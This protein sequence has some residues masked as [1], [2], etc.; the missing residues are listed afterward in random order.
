MSTIPSRTPLTD[1][2]RAR[3]EKLP[4]M[5]HFRPLP[6]SMDP[7][8][9]VDDAGAPDLEPD[10]VALLPRKPST[11]PGWPS[12]LADAALHGF[13]GEF[14]RTVSPHSE[15]D[16][17]ALV[18]SL[19]VGFGNM[20]NAGPHSVVESKPHTLV[21]FA[22]LVGD[23]SKARKGTSWR[24]VARALRLADEEWHDR[25]IM[26]GASSGEGI[27]NAIADPSEDEVNG[28]APTTRDKR[29]LLVEGEFG[30][31][32]SRMR[33]EGN[34]LSEVLRL[35]WDADTLQTVTRAAPMRAS[36]PHVSLL[37]HITRQELVSRIRDVDAFDG[38]SNRI[39]WVAVGRS[40]CLSEG[41]SLADDAYDAMGARLRRL[42]HDAR[43]VGRMER[44][45]DARARW[46]QVY[47]ELSE[48]Q[49]GRLGAVTSRAE[50][51]VLRL[52]MLY[53]LLDGSRVVRVPHLLAALACWRYAAE[54]AE[55]IFG[56][57][58]GDTLADR[59]LTLLRAAPAGIARTD[60]NRAL[61]GHVRAARIS[62]ALAV[63][64][65]K[66]L[67]DATTKPTYGR[68]REVWMARTSS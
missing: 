58:T 42:T 26:S 17:A 54:S 22:V 46:A 15:A 5:A 66:G 53:A 57:G 62:D 48:G 18:F 51:H 40:K 41:G 36:K 67:A 19:L 37:G 64:E 63:L 6:P 60:I 7:T 11:S 13:V 50:A 47:A 9:T 68:P 31:V 45:D 27:I 1:L 21:E 55:W 34:S 3:G 49:S 33:R 43:K 28:T 32:L 4:D 24:P 52:S 12:P 8:S 16:P 56:E 20:V 23:T 29:L 2:L 38:F 25:R 30:A 44:D 14:V 59:L 39:L 10:I 65:E 35:A 61:G